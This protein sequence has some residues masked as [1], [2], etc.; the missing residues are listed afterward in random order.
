MR[1]CS[2]EVGVGGCC[3]CACSTPPGKPAGGA[4]TESI[5]ELQPASARESAAARAAVILRKRMDPRVK[6]GGDACKCVPPPPTPL[7]RPSI[8]LG[9]LDLFGARRLDSRPGA[10]LHPSPHPQPAVLE[11]LGVEAGGG[12]NALI[13]FQDGDRERLRPSPPEIH[14]DCASA[15]ADRQHL[16]FHHRETATLHTEPAS[17]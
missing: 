9:D 14:I 13:P 7:A 11:R 6:S 17:A 8:P 16:A 15:L 3:G 1:W 12:K 4:P 10:I 2:R 5:D